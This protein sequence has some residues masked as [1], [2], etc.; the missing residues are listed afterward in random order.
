MSKVH[1]ILQGKGGVGKSMVA[2]MLTQYKIHQEQPLLCIDTDPVNATFAR[3]QQLN[4]QK[5]DIM[6]GDEINARAFDTML[7]WITETEEEVIIDNGA[8]C[9]VPLSSYLINNAVPVLL[10]ELG[11]K[12]IIH[13]V[14]TG[15]Q[16]L[17][18]TLQG[19]DALMKQFPD[20]CRF[21]VWLNPYFGA[22][23]VEGV[24]FAK[25]KLHEKY[26]HRIAGT[27]EVP[28][29]KQETFGRDFS[30]MLKNKKTFN[31]ALSDTSLN[32]MVRQRLTMIKRQIFGQLDAVAE[33]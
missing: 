30:D 33:L 22:V 8:S 25:T 14:L 29:L 9:F 1:M 11:Y 20:E 6:D 28:A 21:V 7:A 27:I 31:E 23:E 18:D 19:F 16:A 4:V 10:E 2:A 13:T 32:I 3:Y 17:M 24:P 26:H 5:L 15:G 12:T